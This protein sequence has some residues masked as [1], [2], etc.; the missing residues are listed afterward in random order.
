MY[1]SFFRLKKS[2]NFNS[3]HLHQQYYL[4][5][6]HQMPNSLH[7]F[8]NLSYQMANSLVF[9]MMAMLMP[10]AV[11]ALLFKSLFGKQCI[12]NMKFYPINIIF[13]GELLFLVPIIQPSFI[14]I[15]SQEMYRLLLYLRQ[16]QIILSFTYLLHMKGKSD[17]DNFYPK[18]QIQQ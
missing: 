6:G 15:L 3:S 5:L 18:R 10:S 8:S 4:S 2:T 9:V 11:L 12:L 13:T 1:V 14:L 17:N 7:I 16:R